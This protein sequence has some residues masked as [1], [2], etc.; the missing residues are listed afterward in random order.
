MYDIAYHDQPLADKQILV[1]GGAGFIGSNI[2]AYLLRHGIAKVRVLDNLLTGSI[3][4]LH[5]FLN[6]PRFEFMEG[7]IRVLDDCLMACQGMDMICHQA[8]SYTH[9]TLPTTPY[10]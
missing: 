5:P 7:D 4:N 3:D 6:D 2:V 9:L 10:V 1:T 8:V